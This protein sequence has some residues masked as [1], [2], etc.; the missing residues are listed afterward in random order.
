MNPPKY[1]AESVIVNIE[2][3]KEF[4]CSARSSTV[5]FKQIQKSVIKVTGPDAAVALAVKFCLHGLKIKTGDYYSIGGEVYDVQETMNDIHESQLQSKEIGAVPMTG[6]G[7]GVG[8]NSNKKLVS[9][10]RISR[11]FAFSVS[12]LIKKQAVPLP[13]E[14][15]VLGEGTGL[16]IEYMFLAA[17]YGMDDK[18]LKKHA[19]S[20][21]AFCENFTQAVRVAYESGNMDSATGR[22]RDHAADFAN[23][24]KWRRIDPE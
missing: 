7:R 19:K 17:P 3:F 11:A 14:L 16:P 22:A 20:F 24:L 13:Q 1:I 12:H 2:S 8:K 21:L 23:Y 4:D 15:E 5:D 9:T 6:E 10:T 18:V